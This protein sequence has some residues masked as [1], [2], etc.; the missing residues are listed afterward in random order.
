MW[1]ERAERTV[2]LRLAAVALFAFLVVGLDTTMAEAAE[3]S[4]KEADCERIQTL[5]LTDLEAQLR[6]SARLRCED[7]ESSRT[8]TIRHTWEIEGNPGLGR[9]RLRQVIERKGSRG[10]DTVQIL[11]G[12][13]L[14]V[15]QPGTRGWNA[16]RESWGS[17]KFYALGVLLRHGYPVE[18]R[19][20]DRFLANTRPVWVH[21]ADETV[22]VLIPGSEQIRDGLRKG[23]KVTGFLGWRFSFRRIEGRMRLVEMLFLE[24]S[25][26]TTIVSSDGTESSLRIPGEGDVEF[27]RTSYSATNKLTWSEFRRVQGLVIPT[28]YDFKDARAH[29][30]AVIDPASLKPVASFPEGYFGVRA[31]PEW[32]ARGRFHDLRTGETS[33]TE[34]DGPSQPEADIESMANRARDADLDLAGQDDGPSAAWFGLLF[35]A[36]L[37]VVALLLVARMRRRRS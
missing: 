31:P 25:D 5:L 4:T 15:I 17:R 13:A 2:G 23:G 37:A 7:V 28:R 9:W 22:R 30:S 33:V 1:F 6:E 19:R 35:G 18:G 3:G 32:G 10:R 16:S 21:E 34:G 26:R 8:R 24:S 36:L 11:D 29:N 12:D 14:T 27:F 20:L